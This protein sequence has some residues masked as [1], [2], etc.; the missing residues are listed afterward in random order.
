M[1]HR[2]KDRLF[3][4]MLVNTVAFCL[5]FGGYLLYQVLSYFHWHWLLIWF[6]ATCL[7]V[8]AMVV[9]VAGMGKPTKQG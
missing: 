5:A 1:T 2:Q 8:V 6:I 3:N 4:L 7:G 9:L